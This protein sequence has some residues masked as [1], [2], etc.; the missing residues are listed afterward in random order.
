MAG[1]HTGG[2]D[3][4][5][6]SRTNAS[7]R[8]PVADKADACGFGEV[9]GCGIG[10]AIR[11]IADDGDTVVHV[12]VRYCFATPDLDRRSYWLTVLQDVSTLRYVANSEA[13][14]RCDVG[15]NLDHCA[16]RQLDTKAGT[17]R[18]LDHD[19]SIIWMHYDGRLVNR[20]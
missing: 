4:N 10:K 12:S 5:V 9:I 18:L 8:A 17:D 2:N 13:V 16:I 15:C 7:I 11:H 1:A 19:N 3:E 6:I 14:A 20:D